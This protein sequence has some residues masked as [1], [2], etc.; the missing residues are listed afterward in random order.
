MVGTRVVILLTS[1]SH[2]THSPKLY[3]DLL[4]YTDC[5]LVEH[6]STSCLLYHPSNS[7]PLLH[8]NSGSG[9][10]H[11]FLHIC[12]SKDYHT[13]LAT[14]DCTVMWPLL[15]CGVWGHST[16]SRPLSSLSAGG[17]SSI[18]YCSEG[19]NHSM[20]E[21]INIWNRKFYIKQVGCDL[22]I[23]K[24]FYKAKYFYTRG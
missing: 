18:S 4:W 13:V 21:N 19:G 24:Y 16:V 9:S 5:L 12:N 17:Q 23:S 3:G 22:S 10:A 8:S 2:C 15:C 14:R 6:S 7:S 1:S 20:T 11:R